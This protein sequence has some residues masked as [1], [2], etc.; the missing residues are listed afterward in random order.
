MRLTETFTAGVL[1]PFN[2]AGDFFLLASLVA[3]TVTVEFFKGE[4]NTRFTLEGVTCGAERQVPGGFDR[5]EITATVGQVISFYVTRGKLRLPLP[6]TPFAWVSAL[7]IAPLANAVL[8]DTGA[9]SEAHLDFEVNL[10][11]Q[12]GSSLSQ[13]IALE[14]R[15]A[16]NSATLNTLAM[17]GF[18]NDRQASF[19]RYAIAAGERLRVISG[20]VAAQAGAP[21]H[22]ALG[23]RIAY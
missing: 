3:G 6:A 20:T 5:V 9:L 23:A 1:K 10:M 14:H 12:D 4:T 11:C 2:I 18:R 22:A 16:A 8:L 21:Y 19:R 15:N 17:V 13:Y 7:V